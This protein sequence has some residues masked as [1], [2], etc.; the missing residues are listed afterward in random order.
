MLY[1]GHLNV[2]YSIYSSLRR[3]TPE[4]TPLHHTSR[5]VA[6]RCNPSLILGKNVIQNVTYSVLGV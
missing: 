3:A 4:I 5:P 6:P 1:T 2:S